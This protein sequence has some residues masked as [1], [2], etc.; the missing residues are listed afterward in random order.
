VRNIVFDGL[1][2]RRRSRPGLVDALLSATPG[3]PGPP[4]APGQVSV[5]AIQMV[6]RE[7]D[8]PSTWIEQCQA[9]TVAAADAGAQVL[10]FPASAPLALIVSLG[11]SEMRFA[12]SG[13]APNAPSSTQRRGYARLYPAAYRLY[14][15]TFSLLARRAGRTIVAGG[16]PAPGHGRPAHL[17]TVFSADG[18]PRLRQPG[19]GGG[20]VLAAAELQITDAGGSRLAAAI[21]EETAL[22]WLTAAVATTRVDLLALLPSHYTTGGADAARAAAMQGGCYVIQP[23]LVG[24][25]ECGAANGRSGVYAPPAFSSDGSGLVAQ[26]VRAGA[27]E[28]V[29]ATLN[30]DDTGRPAPQEFHTSA[31]RDSVRR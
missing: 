7:S 15:R 3:E 12:Y 6:Y 22:P 13:Q 8:D 31:P 29:L 1:R 20:Q 23:Y 14:H 16:L 27:E 24:G 25:A 21:L 11:G 17:A 5:A 28:I 10:V 26:A 19:V 30:V 4:P 18:R 2:L 9:L